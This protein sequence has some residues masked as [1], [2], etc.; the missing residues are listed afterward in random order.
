MELNEG[1]MGAGQPLAMVHR[2]TGAFTACFS[3]FS[4]LD[5]LFPPPNVPLPPPLGIS[6]TQSMLASFSHSGTDESSFDWFKMYDH[7]KDLI[8]RFI[9]NKETKIVILGC[10]DLSQSQNGNQLHFL[11]PAQDERSISP[12]TSS[13]SASRKQRLLLW[14]RLH[15]NSWLSC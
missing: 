15:C 2:S 1:W 6:A 8:N 4:F 5:P 13:V 9:P 10:G 12:L 14:T 11:T 7:I 3:S